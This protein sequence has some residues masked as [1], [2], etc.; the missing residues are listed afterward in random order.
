MSLTAPCAFLSLVIGAITGAATGAQH[1]LVGLVLGGAG[2]LV[3]GALTFAGFASPLALVD[4]V[5]PS[6]L[7]ARLGEASLRLGSVLILCAPVASG[8]LTWWVV[9]L[10]GR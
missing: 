7:R 9:R 10:V 4:P 1:G 3:T 6:R 5:K 2:G 8:C